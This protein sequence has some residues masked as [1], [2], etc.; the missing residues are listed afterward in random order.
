[1]GYLFAHKSAM[2]AQRTVEACFTGHSTVKN[3]FS[4]EK[5]RKLF[6]NYIRRI[7]MA[8]Q[9]SSMSSSELRHLAELQFSLCSEDD[10]SLEKE[11]AL[12]LMHKLRVHQ[13][14]LEMQ[15]RE[16]ERTRADTT[17]VLERYSHLFMQAPVGYL[18][19][20]PMGVITE[21][22]ATSGQ[23]LGT[24]H[25]PVVKRHFIDF[26][27]E[28]FRSDFLKFFNQ[29]LS[30]SEKQIFE[31]PLKIE[32]RP[33]VWVEIQAQVFPD[34]NECLLTLIDLTNH[35][36]A[37]QALRNA[38]KMEQIGLLTGGIAHDFN[39]LFCIIQGNLELLRSSVK[40]NTKATGQIEKALMGIK[41]GAA[42]TKKLQNF[43]PPKKSVAQVISINDS[44]P[45]LEDV[46]AKSFAL[47]IRFEQQLAPNL[48]PVE[49]DEAELLEAL[50][51][52]H[53]N[54]QEAM[55]AGG[56]LS[57]ETKNVH[58]DQN[59]VR[60][61]PQARPGDFVMVSLRD[62][63][64]GMSEEVMAK[65][66]EP[67]FTTKAPGAGK[68]L[69]LSMAY[70][71][72]CRNGGILTLSSSIHKGTSV[73]MFLPRSLKQPFGKPVEP[74]TPTKIVGGTERVLVVDDEPALLETAVAALTDFGYKTFA[75]NNASEALKILEENSGIELLF[76]DIV[77]PGMNGYQLA[78]AAI[79][80]KPSL[81]VLLTSGF[82]DENTEHLDRGKKFLSSLGANVLHKPYD[83]LA[84]SAAVRARLDKDG[85]FEHVIIVDDDLNSMT[86]MEH[87]LQKAGAK[88]VWMFSEPENALVWMEKHCPRF[89]LLICAQNM[90][91][92][93]GDVFAQAFK[94]KYPAETHKIV[95]VSNHQ[96]P[97]P[98]I[99]DKDG[100][101]PV[102]MKPLNHQKTQ[103][104]FQQ[105]INSSVQSSYH[106]K[107]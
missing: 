101:L 5:R 52:L 107:V 55:P 45:Q 91:K 84:L 83:Q 29:I 85:P 100:N 1:M 22:N 59:F 103:R 90:P 25:S 3:L 13:I 49:V 89:D 21:A 30:S 26:V 71:F 81:K 80:I 17:K 24:K 66:L 82:T 28:P 35:R 69:G 74:K 75:A 87:M 4:K 77:M 27:S 31:A 48:W 63:G 20:S 93:S 57:V 54:A 72:A 79:S 78:R 41:R 104:F 37:E 92:M 53:Q 58:L 105:I 38:Q 96:S 62:T 56:T 12:N 68:G 18:T 65:A 86:L 23:M 88:S 43:S 7:S 67:L 39:N 34:S 51:N 42:I 47:L 98:A 102:Y 46:L 10:T 44:I 2:R 106:E 64:S 73:Q 15:N 99:N 11:E 95:L 70:S 94:E 19:L 14:E 61:H 50:L 76:S 6:F 40:G 60:H 9:N 33:E 36:L 16:L 32:N 97:A 8:S